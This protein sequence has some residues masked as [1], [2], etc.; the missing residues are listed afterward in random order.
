MNF[1]SDLLSIDKALAPRYALAGD[2]AAV[3]WGTP[4]AIDSIEVVVDDRDHPD[5]PR[6]RKSVV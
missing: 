6:D 1:T 4:F 3:L 5:K 2:I